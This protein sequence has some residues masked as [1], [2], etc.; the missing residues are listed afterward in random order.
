MRGDI[1]KTSAEIFASSSVVGG[2]ELEGPL[3]QLFDFCDPCGR[4]GMK[5]WEKSESEMQRMA[6]N[7]ALAKGG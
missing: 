2:K 1:I 6:L 4:F 3:G 7:T 5:T